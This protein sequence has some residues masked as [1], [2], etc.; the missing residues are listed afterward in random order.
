MDLGDKKSNY[1]FPDAKGN[2]LAEGTLATTQAELSE[3]F[4]SI[5]KSAPAACGGP[6]TSGLTKTTF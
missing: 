1:C 6:A 5:S 2:I 3:L 4:L